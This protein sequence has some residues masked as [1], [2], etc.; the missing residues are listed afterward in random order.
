[1]ISPRSRGE[2]EGTA[3]GRSLTPGRTA[4]IVALAGLVITLAVAWTARALNAHNEHG[5]LEVQTRQAAAVLSSTILSIESPLATAL[6]TETA[7]AGNPGQFRRYMSPLTGPGRLF[8]SASLWEAKGPSLRPLVSLGAPPELVAGSDRAREF[9]ASAFRSPSFVVTS[10]G[11]RAGQRIAYA[12]A[13]RHGPA[14]AV[15]AERA[16]PANRRVPVESTPAF[17]DLNY[18]TYLGRTIRLS[19]LATTDLPPA[20]LPLTGATARDVIPFG[21]TTLTLVA[22]P[23]GPLGGA[24]GGALPWIFL[25]GGSLL[26]I[27]TAAAAQ[28]LVRRRR[29]AEQAADT[30]AG[31]YRRLD[32][33]YGKQRTI[34]ETLQRALLPQSNPDIPGL[35]IASRYIAGTDGVEIGGDWYGCVALDDH[36]FGFVVGDVSGRGLSAATVMARLR[37]T[38]RAYL[39]EGHPPDVVL[40]MCSGQ[41][42]LDQD[43]HFSTALVG[44]GD[45]VSGEVTLASAGHPGPLVLSPSGSQYMDLVTGLPLGIEPSSYISTSTF[46]APGST[47]LAF[48]DGLVE[49]RGESIE[50]GLRR[51][52]EAATRPAGTLDDMISGL[53]DRLAETRTEDD[54][55]VL[56]LRWRG[57][58]PAP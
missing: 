49:R 18:A 12:V 29:D 43:G 37:F 27:A 54:I 31:L 9:V 16:I 6:Q 57:T 41:L 8:V 13:L 39:L 47:L 42:D 26:T 51:L 1:M 22:S 45:L 3:A 7:T 56:A 46:M 53:I 11:A 34:A 38:I 55:A 52:A 21:N 35:E 19:A 44:V 48:T 20:D 36:R 2:P 28:E 5:L 58:E 17:A 23:R 14:F 50:T 33:L 40:G 24:L 4:M 10:V 25:V 15:Y 32:G 30:I